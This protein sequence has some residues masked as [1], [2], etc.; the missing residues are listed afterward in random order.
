MKN[1]NILLIIFSLLLVVSSCS[2]DKAER[3][4]P[5][6]PG[7]TNFDGWQ[8]P[9]LS[10]PQEGSRYTLTWSDVGADSY[11]VEE[12][13]TASFTDPTAFTISGTTKTFCHYD[14][15]IKYYYRVK[16]SENS[17]QGGWSNT[18]TVQIND[19]FAYYDIDMVTIDGGTFKI[20]DLNN[21]GA[22][23]ER[24][25]QEVA[26]DM[27]KVSET[28]I[29]QE[30]YET[31]IGE[32]PSTEK[33]GSLPV[34]DISWYDAALFCNR[35]SEL[36]GLDTCYNED[37]W[38]CDFTK[39]GIRLPTEAEWE[40][41]CRA[42]TKTLYHSGDSETELKTEAWY[43]ANSGNKLHEIARKA[44]NAWDLYDMHGNVS[45]WCNDWYRDTTYS[46]ILGSNP[47]G[48]G[49]GTYRSLRGGSFR[50]IAK[51]CRAADRSAYVPDYSNDNIGFR[52]VWKAVEE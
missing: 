43:Y 19:P 9:A 40:F 38:T 26:I 23:D 50:D 22:S 15:G 31:V 37:Y 7:G 52:I 16:N 28:E 6:D 24:P 5:L 46:A 11:V 36:L 25:A 3:D 21:T 33:G 30:L 17:T 47:T 18:H 51:N 44:A 41:A 1:K 49:N 34:T 14:E 27:F 29:S 42:G 2:K 13:T 12:S 20:G 8:T 45:E 4:N 10:G 48:P 39:N 32:N 35:L